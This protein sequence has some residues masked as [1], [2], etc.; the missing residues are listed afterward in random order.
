[1]TIN[2]EKF[3]GSFAQATKIGETCGQMAIV[4]PG[5]RAG[6]GRPA[7]PPGM[8]PNLAGGLGTAGPEPACLDL[9]RRESARPEI[10]LR[11]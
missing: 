6:A 11:P 1:M 3:A 2:P 4:S 7:G 10:R 5:G 9:R 8:R